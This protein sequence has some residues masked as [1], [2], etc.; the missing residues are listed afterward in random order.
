MLSY[1]RLCLGA[2]IRRFAR[3]ERAATA[4]EYG[5]I[6]GILSVAII[7]TILLAKDELVRV[8]TAISEAL[9]QAK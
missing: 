2:T 1:L 9:K 7:T 3:D 4:I 6:A 8:W 5:L